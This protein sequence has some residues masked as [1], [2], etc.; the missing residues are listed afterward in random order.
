MSSRVTLLS[1]FYANT[2]QPSSPSG[3]HLT[4]LI[5]IC[6]IWENFFRYLNNC[7]T[8]DIHGR[9]EVS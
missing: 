8:R 7:E 3:S 1:I 5:R 9:N 2:Y 6:S 4:Q